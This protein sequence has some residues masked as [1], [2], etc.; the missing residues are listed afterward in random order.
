[1]KYYIIAGVGFS[2]MRTAAFKLRDK[3]IAK[4]GEGTVLAQPF[5]TLRYWSH[6]EETPHKGFIITDGYDGL[7][8]WGQ[9]LAANL[10]DTNEHVI[11]WGP[12]VLL[13][14]EKLLNFF[15]TPNS[16]TPTMTRLTIGATINMYV[17]K[18][19]DT[20]ATLINEL[21][22]DWDTTD[23]INEGTGIVNPSADQ[24]QV[25]K[26][27]YF[28]WSSSFVNKASDLW[29]GYDDEEWSVWGGW[30]D[31]GTPTQVGTGMTDASTHTRIDGT[32]TNFTNSTS[33][34]YITTI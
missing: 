11:I 2:E 8:D 32:T 21:K 24:I 33:Q 28:T 23:K 18:T 12:G 15:G 6:N 3:L 30:N 4:H 26:D 9:R 13:N 20:K 29:S 5:G 34:Y 14:Y 22:K 1:M 19:N 31:D 10:A 17:M 16:S 27:Q 25:S 7:G